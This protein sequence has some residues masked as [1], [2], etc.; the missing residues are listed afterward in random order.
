MPLLLCL[1]VSILLAFGLLFGDGMLVQIGP[2]PWEPAHAALFVTGVYLVPCSIQALVLGLIAGRPAVRWILGTIAITGALV[3]AIALL[4]LASAPQNTALW[5]G[6]SVLMTLTLLSGAVWI[7]LLRM[8]GSRTLAY[9]RGTCRRREARSLAA[10]TC[11]PK[12]FQ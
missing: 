10:T 3:T 5:T 9:R 4:V 6:L 8:A 12:S 7:V 2:P 1:V 11:R